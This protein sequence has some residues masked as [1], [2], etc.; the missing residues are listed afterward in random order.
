MGGEGWQR[1]TLGDVADIM[2]GFAFSGRSIHDSPLGDVLLTPGNFA[3][4]GGFQGTTFKYY[5]GEVPADY[6][7]PAGTLIVT[8]TDLSKNADTLG[9]PALVPAPPEGKRFLHNQRLGRVAIRSGVAV[10]ARFLYYVLCSKNYR[11][12]VLAGATGTTVRHTSPGRIKAFSFDLP[13]LPEQKRIAHILGTLDDKIELNRRMCQTLEEM[14][15]ALFKSWFVDFDPVRAKAEGR[16]P[17]GMDAAT[18]ALFPD[19]FVDSEL[20]PIPRG[21]EVKAL[22]DV[23]ELRRDTVDPRK[24]PETEYRH[25]SI[26]SF[27]NGQKAVVE[28]GSGIQSNKYVIPGHGAVLI[29]KLNPGIPRVW[30]V[31]APGE[32][33][34]CSTEFLVSVPGPS[35][36]SAHL[37]GQL[38][39][40]GFQAAFAARARGTTGSHQRV[41]PADFLTMPVVVPPCGVAALFTSAAEPQLALTERCRGQNAALAAARDVLLPRLLS[42]VGH[43]DSMDAVGGQAGRADA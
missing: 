31:V 13:P 4:G 18:A 43:V 22:G 23:A 10:N 32:N 2:H 37:Y 12:E 8:M 34:V 38:T 17:A 24:A 11:D 40:E 21:W 35:W 36:S 19:S 16:Q 42:G 26:P 9:Y 41:T 6:V 20:G 14:A 28:A 25:F 1:V 29:S 33:A 5:R 7:L 3:V 27:D 15:R 39:E 30:L